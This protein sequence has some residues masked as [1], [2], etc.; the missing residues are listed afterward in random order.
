MKVCIDAGH[1]GYDLGAVGHIGVAPYNEKDI[2]LTASLMLA[3]VLNSFGHQNF[4]TRIDD[5]YTSLEDRVEIANDGNCDLFVSIHC[6]SFTS[7]A[8]KGFETYNYPGSSKGSGIARLILGRVEP[9]PWLHI[10]SCK[11]A[12]F[13]VLSHTSMPAVLLELAFL[14]NK[15][16]LQRLLALPNLFL[17]MRL[18]GTAISSRESI[19]II[20]GE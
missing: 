12:T 6:N 9:I 13:H 7:D 17:L 20:E 3:G 18:I 5:V 4:L 11:E 14:S 10:R 15:Y 8:P 19:D 2:N 1:G 16:D